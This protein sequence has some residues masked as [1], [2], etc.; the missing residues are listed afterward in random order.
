M[1]DQL[2]GELIGIDYRYAQGLQ[3]G[4]DSTFTA[5]DTPCQGNHQHHI[6]PDQRR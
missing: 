1:F 6:I 4:G 2:M 5:A 3:M